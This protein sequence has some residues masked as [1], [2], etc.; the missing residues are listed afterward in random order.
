[1]L[2]LPTLSPLFPYPTL[3]RS[4]NRA[5]SW[6]VVLGSDY[7]LTGD[8]GEPGG[9][10]IG[11]NTQGPTDGFGLNY[12]N[13]VSLASGGGGSS[14]AGADSINVFDGTVTV[15]RADYGPY[16]N[17]GPA[18]QLRALRTVDRFPEHPVIVIT[19]ALEPGRAPTAQF[20]GLLPQIVIQSQGESVFDP[21]LTA[22]PT[23]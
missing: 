13:A 19:N 18:G 7:D 20:S 11:R 4:E 21:D 14:S 9:Y 12:P 22:A 2:I 10:R 5:A 15:K 23:E 16:N 6:G 1:M 17:Q 8:T 3:F